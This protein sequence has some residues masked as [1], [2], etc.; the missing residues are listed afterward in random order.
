MGIDT[1]QIEIIEFGST[2]GIAGTD[3][4]KTGQCI[5]RTKRCPS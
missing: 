4:D 3:G 1:E 2:A 5:F